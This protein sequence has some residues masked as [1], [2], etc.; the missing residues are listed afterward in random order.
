MLIFERDIYFHTCSS[1]NAKFR[2]CI[3]QVYFE[4]IHFG[5]YTLIA[6][7]AQFYKNKTG[8]SS[9]QLRE[10]FKFDLDDLK[11]TLEE[12]VCF[13]LETSNSLQR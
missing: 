10:T 5:K 2:R 1:L 3:S 11:A 8:K 4:N 7:T 13:F 9:D 6:Q 12:E